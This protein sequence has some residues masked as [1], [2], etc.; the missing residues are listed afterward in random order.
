MKKSSSMKNWILAVRPK[1][2]PAAVG[3]VLIGFALAF[4]EDAHHLPSV[5]LA[6]VVALLI[7]AG[8]NMVNDYSDF[9]KGVDTEDRV[10]PVRVTQAGLIS[11]EKMKTG[12]GVVLFLIV[13]FSIPLVL[14]GGLPILIIGVLSVVSGILYTA[15]PFPLGYN[16][17]GDIFVLIFF[18]PVAVGG[19]YYVQA[20]KAG[21]VPIIAG[22]GVGLI[23]VAILCI[24]NLRDHEEDQKS[25]K[26]TLNI[27][28]GK[29][30]GK[31]EYLS[32]LILAALVPLVL[33]SIGEDVNYSFL[34]ILI[35]IPAI[36][37]VKVVLNNGKGEVMNKMLSYTG[38]L[39]LLY[40]LL[41][42]IG[43]QFKI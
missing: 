16:G 32:S 8:T 33:F 5:L 24:N 34:T 42:S 30:F 23:S 19:T 31:F 12:M 22:V 13:L 25:G 40:S 18:G 2:L 15:G 11:P 38:K 17:L 9:R 20:L 35:L 37:P 29:N 14:R 41:F 26:N 39:L 10:G 7:Q 27:L 1:T 6:A 3:P 43:W 28:F 4:R 36:K 21:P